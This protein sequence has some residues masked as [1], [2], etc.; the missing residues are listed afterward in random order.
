MG[1]AE[2][3]RHYDRG[4]REGSALEASGHRRLAVY[5]DLAAILL[6]DRPLDMGVEHLL[7]HGSPLSCGFERHIQALAEDLFECVL[8]PRIGAGPARHRTQA[9]LRLLEAQ[10]EDAAPREVP[11]ADMRIRGGYDKLGAS[12]CNGACSK[13]HS[14]PSR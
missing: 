8:E 2:P 12:F 1:R 4:T 10:M 5:L 13:I 3:V 7:G 6:P 14:S 9:F 11:G